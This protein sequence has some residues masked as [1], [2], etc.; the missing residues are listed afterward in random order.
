MVPKI[1]IKNIVT[2]VAIVF[3]IRSRIRIRMCFGPPGSGA[4]IQLFERWK[5]LDPN[6]D[7]YP[8]RLYLQ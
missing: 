4:V 1:A 8:Q 5:T 6:Q 3:R 7:Q 2:I